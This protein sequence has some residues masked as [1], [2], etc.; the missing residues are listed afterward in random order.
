M[1]EAAL[2]LCMVCISEELVT[3]M[4]FT[5]TLVQE[6]AVEDDVGGGTKAEPITEEFITAAVVVV[7]VVGSRV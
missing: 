6:D 7:V 4:L 1:V 2:V 5:I 3:V